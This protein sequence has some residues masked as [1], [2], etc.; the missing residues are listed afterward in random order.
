M[1]PRAADWGM[2]YCHHVKLKVSRQAGMFLVLCPC[3]TPHWTQEVL[4]LCPQRGTLPK[5]AGHS[6]GAVGV[7][8]VFGAVPHAGLA[9][10]PAGCSRGLRAAGPQAAL[11]NQRSPGM[12]SVYPHPPW[13]QHPFFSRKPGWPAATG[14]HEG[15]A[16]CLSEDKEQDCPGGRWLHTSHR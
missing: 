6:E 3:L 11:P 14:C 5:L 7:S 12:G 2:F 15:R 10:A 9:Q 8:Y 4:S 1:I 16:M 13:G